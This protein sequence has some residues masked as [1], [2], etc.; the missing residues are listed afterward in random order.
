MVY[1]IH[2]LKHAQQFFS[3][4]NGSLEGM[5]ILSDTCSD[6]GVISSHDGSRSDTE[7]DYNPKPSISPIFSSLNQKEQSYSHTSFKR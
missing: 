7:C 2:N 4:T 6:S 5:P 3:D 1:L